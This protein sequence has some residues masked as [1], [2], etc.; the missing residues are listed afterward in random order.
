MHKGCHSRG[1]AGLGPVVDQLGLDPFGRV[2]NR[3]PGYTPTP[4]SCVT[5]RTG[6]GDETRS[7]FSASQTITSA[8]QEARS[9]S[10][11]VR[12]RARVRRAN[13]PRPPHTRTAYLLPLVRRCYAPQAVAQV[14]K[15]LFDRRGHGRMADGTHV[16]DQVLVRSRSPRSYHRV[17]AARAA[18]AGRRV[19]PF[20]DHRWVVTSCAE[21]AL[22]LPR[23]PR[24]D[25][26]LTM[27]ASAAPA[28]SFRMVWSP[29]S[30]APS[31]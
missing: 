22:R 27:M 12:P 14:G 17:L 28:I 16:A 5:T 19:A 11:A 23:T 13:A 7:G 6:L 24:V 8:G 15:F 29:C 30:A 18:H 21:I 2:D 20:R 10:G 25:T 3:S 4:P 1:A 31:V 26:S 9:R